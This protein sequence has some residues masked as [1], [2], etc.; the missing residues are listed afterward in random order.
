[1]KYAENMLDIADVPKKKLQVY[2]VAD[3]RHN[4][5]YIITIPTCGCGSLLLSAGV[6]REL[7]CGPAV[8]FL[9]A[10]AKGVGVGPA[11]PLVDAVAGKVVVLVLL[12]VLLKMSGLG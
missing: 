4:L 12:D 6:M 9:S 7:S 3:I 5:L 11:C 2:S 10:V 8:D 1:M